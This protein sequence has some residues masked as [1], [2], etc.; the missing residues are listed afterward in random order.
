MSRYKVTRVSYVNADNPQ[1]AIDNTK[2]ADPSNI[3]AETQSSD[4]IVQTP[5]S[6]TYL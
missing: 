6:G 1:D 3:Y 5:Q 2:D 4:N